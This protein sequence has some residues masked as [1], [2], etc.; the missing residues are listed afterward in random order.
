MQRRRLRQ[1]ELVIGLNTPLPVHQLHY[2]KYS[3]LKL[4]D[5]CDEIIRNSQVTWGTADH[6]LIGP[7]ELAETL[8]RGCS[9]AEWSDFAFTDGIARIDD[10]PET[11]LIDMES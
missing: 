4:P 2:V 7:D 8:I 9:A 11:L 3:D 5:Y 6:T 10:L 1:S